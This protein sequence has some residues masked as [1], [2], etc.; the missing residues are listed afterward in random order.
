MFKCTLEPEKHLKDKIAVKSLRDVDEYYIFSHNTSR[1]KS[2]LV[3]GLS[4]F[5]KVQ[6]AA[7]L[8]F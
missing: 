2:R 4:Y 1:D 6:L 3:K 5:M 7:N 8:Y